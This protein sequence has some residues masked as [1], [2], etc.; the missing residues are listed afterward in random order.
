VTFAGTIY[1]ARA[2]AAVPLAAATELRFYEADGVTKTN[3]VGALGPP[4]NVLQ[5][6][7][8]GVSSLEVTFKI[9]SDELVVSAGEAVGD[10]VRPA[11]RGW[12]LAAGE[13]SQVLNGDYFLSSTMITGILA[14]TRQARIVADLGV[15]RGEGAAAMPYPV[16]GGRDYLPDSGFPP[17]GVA[18]R[19]LS[20][21]LGYFHFAVRNADASIS[22]VV[23]AVADTESNTHAPVDYQAFLSSGAGLQIPIVSGLWSGGEDCDA[24]SGVPQTPAVSYAGQIQ[25]LWNQYC[26][27]CHGADASAD[28]D[29]R[30]G[31]SL[32]NLAGALSDGVPGVF[33]VAAQRPERSFLME[34]INCAQPQTGTRMMPTGTLSL[35]E[36]ALVRD[37]I[38]QLIEIPGL[39]FLDGFE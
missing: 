22:F 34:K 38:A 12:R 28:L 7:P 8:G 18:H 32:L 19:V 2:L 16:S 5:V 13:A 9:S 37:W 39:L 14:D 11:R 10:G 23:D 33:R 4:D 26:I 17:T 31:S 36:Q 20:D 15:H 6:S 30:P 35:A 24:L 1:D 25:P 27:G 21:A 3:L 29:L